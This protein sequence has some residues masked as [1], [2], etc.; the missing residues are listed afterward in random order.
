MFPTATIER[1][2]T[3]RMTAH[4]CFERAR[5]LGYMKLAYEGPLIASW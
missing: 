3:R 5:R 4:E 2:A 1:D